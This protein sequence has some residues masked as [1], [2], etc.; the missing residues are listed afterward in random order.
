MFADDEAI[1]AMLRHCHDAHAIAELRRVIAI[2]E[3]GRH[4]RYPFAAR[5][6][7]DPVFRSLIHGLMNF[8]IGRRMTVR[9]ALAH[10]FFADVADFSWSFP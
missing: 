7:F 8:E 9:E 2:F 4:R 6:R 1:E 3:N 5:E 10:P